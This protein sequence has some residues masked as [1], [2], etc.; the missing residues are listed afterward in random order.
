MKAV[1]RGD[2]YTAKELLSHGADVSQENVVRMYIYCLSTRRMQCIVG[3]LEIFF[4]CFADSIA[5]LDLS[6]SL[7]LLSICSRLDLSHSLLLLSML[8]MVELNGKWSS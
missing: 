8:F 7:L 5:Q 4:F 3:E 1:Y 6:R 2:F